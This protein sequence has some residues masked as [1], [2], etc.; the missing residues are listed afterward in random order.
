VLPFGAPTRL[1]I[2]EKSGHYIADQKTCRTAS[3]SPSPIA[4]T[5]K[6]VIPIV[7]FVIQYLA[8][9]YMHVCLIVVYQN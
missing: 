6:H 7:S 1:R 3:V 9:L 2:K 8:Y 4:Q 5:N